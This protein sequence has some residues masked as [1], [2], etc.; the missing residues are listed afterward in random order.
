VPLYAAVWIRHAELGEL[1]LL[2]S[3]LQGLRI[4][5]LGLGV[6]VPGPYWLNLLLIMGF[7]VEAA[8][9][10]QV[11]GLAR[12]PNIPTA[13]E[14]IFTVLFFVVAVGLLAFRWQHEQ[15]ARRLIVV[16]L[17]A[18]VLSTIARVFL[19]V[20]DQANTPL[21][22]LKLG[23]ALLEM[24]G[25][26]SE[27]T[28][29]RMRRAIDRI[30]ELNGEFSRYESAVEWSGEELQEDAVERWLRSQTDQPVGAVNDE[31]SADPRL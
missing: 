12:N 7:A 5:V 16:E 14:P 13:N 31:N 18:R 19:R 22:N 28:T 15:M 11:F 23:L 27:D 24:R 21:Q 29:E 3:P 4:V 26:G 8:V 17:R 30:T 20:R 10:W 6:I 25:H 9:I 1:D 2:W